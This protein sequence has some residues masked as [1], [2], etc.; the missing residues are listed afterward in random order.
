M[1]AFGFNNDDAVF[2]ITESI[3]I[4][5]SNAPVSPDSGTGTLY[6]RD[7][8][9]WR[10]QSDGT[11][12]CY[13]DYIDEVGARPRFTITLMR[14]GSITNNEFVVYSAQLGGADIVI[15]KN[16]TLKEA[17]F[18]CNN[19]NADWQFNFY[20]NGTAVG[21]Q[22][23]TWSATNTKNAYKNDFSQAFVAGDLLYV[24]HVDIGDRPSDLAILLFFQ[25]TS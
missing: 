19:V 17:T 3:Y 4:N 24:K 10:K 12:R 13:D 22:F 16:C 11:E 23:A 1:A 21:N 7:N 14:D 18:T 2:N 8:K 25:I 20:R 9:L 6:I 15:P 5:R